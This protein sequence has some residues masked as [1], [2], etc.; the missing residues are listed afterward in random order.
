MCA[1]VFVCL[2]LCAKDLRLFFFVIIIVDPKQIRKA[3]SKSAYSVSKLRP[4]LFLSLKQKEVKMMKKEN[5][6]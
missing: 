2:F 4:Y 5:E 6:H 1:Y 3:K